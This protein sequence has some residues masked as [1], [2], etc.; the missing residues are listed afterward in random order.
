MAY[1]RVQ[2]ADDTVVVAVGRAREHALSKPVCESIQLIAGIG[3]ESDAHAGETVKHRW[4]VERD[5]S[6]PNLR[7]VHLLSEELID[8]L[9]A[10][11]FNVGPG[12]L[13]E[14]VTTRG[15]ELISLPAGTRLRLGAE[16]VV[17]VTGLRYPCSQL[18]EL[19]PGLF[20]A[21]IGE[22]D[23]GNQI[24]KPG[25]MSIVVTGGEVRPG[26]TIGVELPAEPHA[27]LKPV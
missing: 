7:Q 18:D 9:N 21:V 6:A 2:A 10:D 12:D 17:E 16:A 3:V 20:A 22:D 1:E 11:G 23:H 14:N 15:L 5:P 24:L 27:A 4:L 19:Q 26:D 25:V 8:E 13:G